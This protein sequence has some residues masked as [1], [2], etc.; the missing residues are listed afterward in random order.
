MDYNIVNALHFCSLT[1]LLFFFNIL[2]YHFINNYQGRDFK[3][4]SVDWSAF[5]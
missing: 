5:P 1:L 4:M 3:E 2:Y